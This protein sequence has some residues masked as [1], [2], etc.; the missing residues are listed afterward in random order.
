MPSRTGRVAELQQRLGEVAMGVGEERLESGRLLR[1]ETV[2]ECPRRG[3]EVTHR[4]VGNRGE[5]PQA[6]LTGVSPADVEC[7]S[8][9]R[10]TLVGS[11]ERSA[12]SPLVRTTHMSSQSGTPTCSAKAAA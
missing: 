7:S 9:R 10:A 4:A 1:R 2:V 6:R 3:V 5:V 11:F 12:S 8:A